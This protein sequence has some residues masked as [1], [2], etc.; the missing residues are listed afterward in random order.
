[1]NYLLESFFL[2]Q[3]HQRILLG[4]L[5]RSKRKLS[6]YGELKLSDEKIFKGKDLASNEVIVFP[7]VLQQLKLEVGIELQLEMVNLSLKILGISE[8]SDKVFDTGSVAPKILITTE[9]IELAKVLKKGKHC[10]LSY[11]V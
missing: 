7:E 3:S 11:C 5:A 8:D 4:L 10:R 2:W 6:F 9:G 1:M